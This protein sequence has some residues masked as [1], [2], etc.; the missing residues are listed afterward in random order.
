MIGALQSMP[1]VVRYSESGLHRIFGENV[2][3]GAAEL[4][5]AEL[6]REVDV[7]FEA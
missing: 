3:P 1:D 2:P 7:F 4:L 5:G 6:P